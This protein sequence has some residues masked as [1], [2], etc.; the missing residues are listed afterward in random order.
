MK[1]K[2]FTVLA[3]VIT[4]SLIVVGFNLAE[5][6]GLIEKTLSFVG[7]HSQPAFAAQMSDAVAELSTADT[8]YQS[9]IDPLPRPPFPKPKPKPS[10]DEPELN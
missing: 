10:P 4:Y 7:L 1:K 2:L 8:G 3:V 5:N 9:F 6:N